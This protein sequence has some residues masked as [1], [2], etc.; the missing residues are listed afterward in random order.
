[1]KKIY[2]ETVKDHQKNKTGDGEKE[3]GLFE[4]DDFE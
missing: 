3:G 2:E 4:F 1:L